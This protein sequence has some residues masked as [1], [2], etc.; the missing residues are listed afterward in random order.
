MLL[1]LVFLGVIGETFLI[2]LKDGFGLD[3]LDQVK[4]KVISSGGQVLQEY[5]IIPMLKVE[6]TRSA[7]NT[8]DLNFVDIELDA[9][10]HS[11]G[12]VIVDELDE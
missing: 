5:E 10:V 8:L 7:V 3:K 9:Q 2:T 4:S 6:M 12:P 1:P 11:L